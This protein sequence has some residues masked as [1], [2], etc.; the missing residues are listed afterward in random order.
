MSPKWP[1]SS[2]LNGHSPAGPSSFE[3]PQ[4]EAFLSLHYGGP[5]QDLLSDVLL[6]P[7]R[8]L[9]DRRCKKIRARLVQLGFEL[10]LNGQHPNGLSPHLEKFQEIIEVLHAG[11]LAIDDVQDGS[12]MRRGDAC[13]HLRYG[14]PI[15]LNTG[16]TLYFWPLEMIRQMHLAIKTEV[17]LYRLYH[18]TLLRA[19][20]GQAL[21]VGVSVD[22][23]P[24][25][26]VA[27][28]SLAAIEL[29]SGALTALALLMGA[30]GTQA[31]EK[32][33]D[34]L[35]EFGHGFGMGLQM[36]DD[37]GNLKGATEPAKRWEDLMLRRP[38]WVWAVAARNYPK[39]IYEQFVWGV[40]QLPNDF[41]LER[42]FKQHDFV[43]LAKSLA[44]RHFDQCF[45]KLN[46]YPFSPVQ[47]ATL[48]RLAG[49]AK[50]VAQAYG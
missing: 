47:L 38:T 50:D 45:D 7:M 13:L 2:L 4:I 32:L 35:D 17:A 19:H 8:D 25:E 43:A 14:L 10:A 22:A 6:R 1:V 40:R 48:G 36:F 5:V 27:H 21:D 15:A 26:R 28:V 44:Q 30:V 46:Q 33:I 37:V 3:P 11:S 9:L 34:L 49:L 41:Y 39:E 16:N 24:Q 12:K 31:E 29:K 18:R 42:W 23:L 20:M